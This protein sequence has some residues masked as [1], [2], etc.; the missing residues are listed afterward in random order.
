M[1][2]SMRLTEIRDL[3][4][5][6]QSSA[7]VRKPA[8][9]GQDSPSDHSYLSVDLVAT[10]PSYIRDLLEEVNGAFAAGCFTA[11]GMVLR[12]FAETLLIEAFERKDNAHLIQGPGGEWLTLEGIVA[13]AEQPASLGLTRNARKALAGIKK[14]GD[15]SAHDRHFVAKRHHLSRQ[16][17]DVEVAVQGLLAV[18][19]FR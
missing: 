4:S 17:L 7:P 11:C 12:R 13:V 1:T 2:A 10:T 15:L 5:K 19:G 6:L 9:T 3:A 18:C 14:I 16:Q 8:E